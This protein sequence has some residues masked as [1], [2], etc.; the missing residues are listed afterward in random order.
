[1]L[2]HLN[3]D[4]IKNNE[5]KKNQTTSFLINKM[6]KSPNK[7]KNRNININTLNECANLINFYKANLKFIFS[8]ANHC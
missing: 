4:I 3:I 5:N 7:K 6:L 8:P 1:M 2:S